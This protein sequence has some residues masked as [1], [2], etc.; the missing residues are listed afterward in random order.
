MVL[1]QYGYKGCMKI[2]SE[3]VAEGAAIYYRTERFT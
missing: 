2:K 1:G 3:K